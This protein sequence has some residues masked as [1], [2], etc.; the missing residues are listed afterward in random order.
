MGFDGQTHTL[1]GGLLIEPSANMR[2]QVDLNYTTTTGS[3]DVTLLDWRAD[4]GLTVWTGGEL[5][6]LYRNVNY[7]DQ[8][9]IDD[10]DANIV[11]LYWRQ[12]I[13]AR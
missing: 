4:M 7:R 12:I 11:F 3:F 8:N 10:Y 5:G 13:G 1:T 2:W 9:R 6:V